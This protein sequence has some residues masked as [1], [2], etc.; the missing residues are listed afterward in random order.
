M[1]S[2]CQFSCTVLLASGVLAT[3][4]GVDAAARHEAVCQDK[5]NPAVLSSCSQKTAESCNH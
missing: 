5:V 1:C 4:H 3:S 2:W